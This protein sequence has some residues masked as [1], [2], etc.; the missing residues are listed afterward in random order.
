[1][2]QL[3]MLLKVLSK[4]KRCGMKV[5]SFNYRRSVGGW[6]KNPGN[7]YDTCLGLGTEFRY[8]KIP[9][10]R[11]GIVSVLPWKKA[12]IPR[13]SEFRGR[14]DSV[15]RNRTERNGIPREKNSFTKQQQNNFWIIR[16]FITLQW[17]S[18][19]TSAHYIKYKSMNNAFF[20]LKNGL[21]LTPPSSFS[22]HQA[23]VAKLFESLGLT[24]LR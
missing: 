20:P 12:L 21:H 1:M 16:V 13:H 17:N 14:A 4:E 5:V 7:L 6:W 3:K 18:Y 19:V 15:A 22:L 8:E 9:R 2:N 24:R 11:L 23:V 10:N